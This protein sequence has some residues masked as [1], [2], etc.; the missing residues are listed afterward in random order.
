MELKTILGKLRKFNK[1]EM[2]YLINNID[3]D[4]MDVISKTLIQRLNY[5][6]NN[7]DNITLNNTINKIE[8]EIQERYSKLYFYTYYN[9]TALNPFTE[10]RLKSFF[11]IKLKINLSFIFFDRRDVKNPF[12]ERDILNKGTIEFE[13]NEFE[14]ISLKN[15][16]HDN[17]FLFENETYFSN[18]VLIEILYVKDES[19]NIKFDLQ[20][21][22]PTLITPLSKNPIYL[23][24]K[25]IEGNVNDFTYKISYQDYK[26]H[27]LY[28]DLLEFNK[29]IPLFSGNLTNF[30]CFLSVNKDNKTKQLQYLDVVKNNDGEDT[31]A[32][33]FYYI[34]LE[35]NLPPLDNGTTKVEFYNF[36]NEKISTIDVNIQKGKK[37]YPLKIAFDKFLPIYIRGL[38]L[39]SDNLGYEEITLV[40]EKNVNNSIET[41]YN[42]PD[43]YNGLELYTFKDY[44]LTSN[45]YNINKVNAIR[46]INK[47]L[48]YNTDA[49]KDNILICYYE[50]Y[51]KITKDIDIYFDKTDNNSINK[52]IKQ[53]VALEDI[54]T[55]ETTG[56]SYFKLT[57]NLNTFG[58]Y[59]TNNLN[60]IINVK[61]TDGNYFDFY[62]MFI[63]LP[64]MYSNYINFFN[65]FNDKNNSN[66]FTEEDISNNYDELHDFIFSN[67]TVNEVNVNTGEIQLTNE[68][69]ETEL[70]HGV[71]KN[72]IM[73]HYD[74]YFSCRREIQ[75]ETFNLTD[76]IRLTSTFI[77]LQ[78]IEG[79]W[80][81]ICPEGLNFREC[82]NASKSY[83]IRFSIWDNLDPC[84][85]Y[86][87]YYGWYYPGRRLQ[88]AGV[89]GMIPFKNV[90]TD[91]K[92]KY[93]MSLKMVCSY[94]NSSG[95]SNNYIRLQFND[96]A[97]NYGNEVTVEYRII[98]F[99]NSNVTKL[100]N[101]NNLTP[102]TPSGESYLIQIP[103]SI[104][105]NNLHV[106]MT[107]KFKNGTVPLISYIETKRNLIYNDVTSYINSTYPEIKNKVFFN[108]DFNSNP[109][110][111][112][113]IILNDAYQVKHL[114]SDY[115]YLKLEL[116]YS[117]T[118]DFII[119][120]ESKKQIKIEVSDYSLD[121]IN[122]K[123][124]DI[125]LPIIFLNDIKEYSIFD[126]K[127]VSGPRTS[128]DVFIGF[129]K[130]ETEKLT[131]VI[132]NINSNN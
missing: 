71:V 95:S 12:K 39:K 1:Y 130:E 4:K 52:V 88:N 131:N 109:V 118:S 40:N 3:K 16:I 125:Y 43:N 116:L 115:L 57:F 102:E 77:P 32:S 126:I 20:K 112:N 103:N 53:T 29:V 19:N 72:R 70:F 7:Y 33:N 59:Y 113:K 42:K 82:N 79:Q 114:N 101:L 127:P 111:K 100:Y 17:S 91:Y 21:T 18:E 86:S 68:N 85:S 94:I 23:T 129:N 123:N 69:L 117:V 55:D 80:V 9:G 73:Y 108:F 15:L 96:K 24:S 87:S 60:S 64:K 30:Y 35:F 6:Q 47:K 51:Q 11:D 41:K 121:G 120:F 119:E 107:I 50:S 46:M 14:E 34:N 2:N 92:L 44:N 89:P 65:F 66:A 28:R 122:L 27:D 49:G 97:I 90:L 105:N 81:F 25:F 36:L 63:Y 67:L 38:I 13:L 98:G 45:R 104:I 124:F 83:G 56:A 61:P 128:L 54:I 110:L 37:V 31:L 5:K 8:E 76:N 93:S 75:I 84:Y 74:N 22:F 132:N 26:Y 58:N 78:Y 106:G 99:D 10:I 48:V 62:D